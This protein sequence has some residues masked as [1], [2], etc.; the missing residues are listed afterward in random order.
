VDPTTGDVFFC[1]FLRKRIGRLRLVTG[2]EAPVAAASPP[3][4][5]AAGLQ[6]S[7][8]PSP[9]RGRVTVTV[10]VPAPGPVAVAVYDLLGRRV[11][12][13]HEGTAPAGS[14]RLALDGST[15]PAG[16]YVVRAEG[17]GAVATARVALVR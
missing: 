7:A 6:V 2:S 9:A 1:E 14:L 8:Y 12:M 15:L 17:S 13:L 3:A 16:V 11:A 10:E 5:E 4:S